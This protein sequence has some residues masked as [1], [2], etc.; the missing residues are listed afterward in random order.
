MSLLSFAFSYLSIWIDSKLVSL[1]V[2]TLLVTFKT[3]YFQNSYLN[4]LLYINPYIRHQRMYIR[5]QK[6]KTEHTLQASI[7]F[8]LCAF[9]FIEVSCFFLH[10]ES[11]EQMVMIQTISWAQYKIPLPVLSFVF[12]CKSLLLSAGKTTSP[13][14]VSKFCF[15]C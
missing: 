13:Q 7:Q 12:H 11:H 9:D 10:L 1:F 6:E 5:K 8:P 4:I 2:W 14:I 3:W 15:L